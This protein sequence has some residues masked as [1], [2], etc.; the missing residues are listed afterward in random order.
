[1]ESNKRFFEDIY[2]ANKQSIF[3]FA[4]ARTNSREDA[5]DITA[6]VFLSAWENIDGFK[7][8]SSYRTWLFAICRHKVSDY[9]RKS[10]KEK[11][12][13]D[14]SYDIDNYNETELEDNSDTKVIN[15]FRFPDLLGKLKE[16]EK[17]LILLKYMNNLNFSECA[18]VLRVSETNAR[19]MHHRIISKLK[20]SLIN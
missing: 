18:D 19:V 3:L 7:G 4:L 5:L 8:Q 17:E 14:F 11:E 12:V 13:F 9:Y 6:E 20:N 15:K 1:M 10:Y 2:N 16:A